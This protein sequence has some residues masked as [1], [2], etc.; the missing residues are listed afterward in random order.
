[1]KN[2]HPIECD[3]PRYEILQVMGFEETYIRI[4][5]SSECIAKCWSLETAQM[6][7]DAL[8]KDK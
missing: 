4:I 1:M 3:T 6:I 8:N 2:P 5:G 7:C